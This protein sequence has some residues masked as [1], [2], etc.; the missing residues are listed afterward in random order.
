MF[1]LTNKEVIVSI[2]KRLEEFNFLKKTNQM[3]ETK[4]S[5]LLSKELKL[6]K[7]EMKALVIASSI[8]GL[9]SSSSSPLFE[10]FSDMGE[11]NKIIQ[12]QQ[13]NHIEDVNSKTTLPS[14]ILWF[15]RNIIEI[16]QNHN[17]SFFKLSDLEIYAKEKVFHPNVLIA[18]QKLTMI[19][20]FWKYLKDVNIYDIYDEI[21]EETESN[22]TEDDML[23]FSEAIAHLIDFRCHYTF[24]HSYTVANI[25]YFISEKLG[26]KKEDCILFKIVGYL[27]DIGKIG[28]NPELLEKPGKLTTNE[29]NH[30]RLH[31]TYTETILSALNHGPYFNMIT[32]LAA[33]HHERLD[34]SG[35]PQGIKGLRFTDEMKIIAYSDVITALTENRPYREGLNTERAFEIIRISMADKIGSKLF[36]ELLPYKYEIHDLIKDCREKCQKLYMDYTK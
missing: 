13:S 30:I 31:A 35:Y 9:D 6:K 32:K 17:L 10:Y 12:N 27:H 20:D 36:E 22:F 28:V 24:S 7:S 14:C 19:D 29:F 4:L 3:L 33:S 21:F 5:Y 16:M 2:V 18:F 34:G 11:I 25:A 1:G 8:Y 26:Y 15:V 23:K